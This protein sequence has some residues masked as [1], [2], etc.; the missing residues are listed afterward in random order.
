MEH[1][2][3][4][5]YVNCECAYPNKGNIIT[6]TYHPLPC[7]YN[8]SLP[9]GYDKLSLFPQT[10]NIHIYVSLALRFVSAN[11]TGLYLQFFPDFYCPELNHLL[12]K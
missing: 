3:N 12:N 4:A 8:H 6:L 1:V 7:I 5:V 2:A 11:P 9:N 10:A